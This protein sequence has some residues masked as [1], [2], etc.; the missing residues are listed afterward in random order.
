MGIKGDLILSCLQTHGI[1][2]PNFVVSWFFFV[3]NYM[4]FNPNHE[5]WKDVRENLPAYKPEGKS[6][7]EIFDSHMSICW[8]MTMEPSLPFSIRDSEYGGFGIFPTCKSFRVLQPFLIGFCL[9]ITKPC[10]TALT[11][12]KIGFGSIIES[13]ASY[14][15]LYGP[16][17]FVNHECKNAFKFLTDSVLESLPF[18]QDSG[19]YINTAVCGVTSYNDGNATVLDPP[20]TSE[21]IE[22]R[23]G[24]EFFVCY[25]HKSERTPK[26]SC[27]SRDSFICRCKVCHEVGQKKGLLDKSLIPTASF[28][29]KRMTIK[30]SAFDKCAVTS[31]ARPA[32]YRDPYLQPR[33]LSCR[34]LHHLYIQQS[35]VLVLNQTLPVGNRNRDDSQSTPPSAYTTDFSSISNP[36]VSSLRTSV[37]MEPLSLPSAI[38][39]DVLLEGAVEPTAA[40]DFTDADPDAIESDVQPMS[41]HVKRKCKHNWFDPYI[42]LGRISMNR[43][44]KRKQFVHYR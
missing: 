6:K 37:V 31:C 32:F 38:T 26:I 15:L 11:G 19:L 35:D 7:K 23:N 22:F 43:A 34:C 5:F 1:D 29:T 3:D 2:V 33:N 41:N 36:D 21:D 30:T 25:D 44:K 4:G 27:R 28:V 14:N 8:A 42:R 24:E 10:Y 18:M 16:I 20:R 39:L 17:S 40:A 13:N 12:D 9:P